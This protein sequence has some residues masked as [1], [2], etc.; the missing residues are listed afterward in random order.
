[1]FTILVVFTVEWRW[2]RL[3]RWRVPPLLTACSVVAFPLHLTSLMGQF[4]EI[5]KALHTVDTKFEPQR[6][7]IS[8]RWKC[9]A[10][11]LT[12]LVS[13]DI[14]FEEL[15]TLLISAMT[16]YYLSYWEY[17]G[18]GGRLV[19]RQ[20]NDW[21]RG[22]GREEVREMCSL[23]K[24]ARTVQYLFKSLFCFATEMVKIS[25]DTR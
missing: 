16:Y 19:W 15:A 6:I 7:K 13:R 5:Y 22:G 1:M 17:R 20:E 4:Q 21:G 24:I 25:E 2:H 8:I 9:M 18:G 11:L 3:P 23:K 10:V 12:I 14:L